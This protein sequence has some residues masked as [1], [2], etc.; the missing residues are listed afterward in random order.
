MKLRAKLLAL[1]A[2]VGVGLG[3]V[4]AASEAVKPVPAYV[5]IRVGL[6]GDVNLD[7]RVDT[8]DLS[9]IAR[10]FN[11]PDP[12]ADRNGDGVVDILDLA[13]AGKEYG[14]EVAP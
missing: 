1:S 6:A 4:Y 9:L 5:S 10:S 3:A 8:A 14:K 11:T 13:I 7:H 12:T 2:A